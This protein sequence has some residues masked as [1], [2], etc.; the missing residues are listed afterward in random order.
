MLE[1]KQL[2][3]QR[4]TA[5]LFSGID[6]KLGPGDAL[7]VTG[8]NGSGK[9]TLLRIAAGLS[10]AALGTLSWRGVAVA[11][12]DPDLREA[13]T[14]IGHAPALK[15]E[16]TAEENLASL[17]TLHA[18]SL[19]SDAIGAALALW[20]LERQRA[21][22]AR[23]LSMGQRRRIGLARLALVPRPLWILDEPAAA[24][25]TAGVA[26]L[27]DLLG[28]HLARGGMAIVATHQ[29]IGLSGPSVRGLSLA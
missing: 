19:A 11:P 9:T 29:D 21:L 17:A 1:S 7:L 14:Y 2:A 8:A 28:A 5:T 24:L 4:G 16:L 13:V 20:S 26:L 27:C 3:A 12:L 18:G 23:A 6:F 10:H 25:D 15:D 22:P